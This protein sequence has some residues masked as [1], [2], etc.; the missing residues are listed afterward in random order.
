MTRYPIRLLQLTDLHLLDDPAGEVQGVVTQQALEA[1]IDHGL[2]HHPDTDLVLVTGDLVHDAGAQAYRRLRATLERFQRPVY[3]LPGN[4]DRASLL[5]R[6]LN[7]ERVRAPGAA[8]HG[9]WLI[10]FLDSHV[11]GRV[12]GHLDGR[13]F[14]HLGRMLRAS[15]A[16]YVLLCLHHP[17]VDLGSSW[18]DASRVDNG[19]TLLS[20][21]HME[22][23]I[24]ALAFGHVH[25]A[26]HRLF[27]GRPLLGTPATCFQFQPGTEHC[28]LDA[29]PPGYRWIHLHEDG[30][31]ATGIE[32]LPARPA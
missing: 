1:V 24:R 8:R 20:L 9:N 15:G 10:L 31:L 5:R 23:R 13:Q 25:Q 22:P 29:R 3:C 14:D 26:V 17:P 21:V 27:D 7:S 18:L 2:R 19:E 4:H 11:E 16:P 12:H 28:A 6:H 32:R 30:T